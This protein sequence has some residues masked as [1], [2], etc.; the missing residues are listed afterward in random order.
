M[1]LILV[2]LVVAIF[3]I[4][5]QCQ[6]TL[7]LLDSSSSYL[8]YEGLDVDP[9]G[10]VAVTLR[11]YQLNATVL[12]MQ[13]SN[14]T[15]IY[16]HLVNG[17]IT[18]TLDDG[19]G[20]QTISLKQPYNDNVWRRVQLTRTSTMFRLMDNG[21]NMLEL[22]VSG[23]FN[24][25]S[26]IFVGGTP[27]TPPFTISHYQV[28]S[29]THFVGCVR[30]VQ[31]SNSTTATVN[32]NPT[33]YSSDVMLNTCHL[34]CDSM[35]CDP[36]GPGNGECIEYYTHGVCDCRGVSESEGE[37]CT[38]KSRMILVFDEVMFCC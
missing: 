3:G 9:E 18:L 29:N 23:V 32:V 28:L 26:P 27:D 31:L 38:G 37:Q 36:S 15:F 25:L 20:T 33:N 19:E 24:I 21:S 5:I 30:R 8:T 34:A 35:D 7:T 14:G 2:A 17:K 22:S 6:R 13:G 16:L 4:P 12:Y 1:V 11:T 10:A